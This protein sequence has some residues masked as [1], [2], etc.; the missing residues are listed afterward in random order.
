MVRSLNATITSNVM[1]ELTTITSAEHDTLRA[2][3]P[4]VAGYEKLVETT[5]VDGK[6]ISHTGFFSVPYFNGQLGRLVV[7]GVE[8]I[9]D[10]E[11]YRILNEVQ[12]DRVAD[13][14]PHVHAKPTKPTARQRKRARKQHLTAL[15]PITASSTDP[16]T[17]TDG[18]SFTT[19][20]APRRGRQ[21]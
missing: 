18:F 20:E 2:Y 17:T 21:S 1:P 13:D 11:E 10:Y 19:M 14:R 9:G 7:V 6:A 12:D 8:V 4:K 16:K 3:F 5:Y 15:T